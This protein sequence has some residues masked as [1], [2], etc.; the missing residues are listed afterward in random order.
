M[1]NNCRLIFI[2]KSPNTAQNTIILPNF[3]M[4]T[5][6]GKVQL[7]HSFDRFAANSAEFVPFHKIFTPGI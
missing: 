7:P 6:C 4:L 2:F 5:F 3:L 1:E